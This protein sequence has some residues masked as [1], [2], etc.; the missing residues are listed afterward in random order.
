[1]TLN[2]VIAFILCFFSPNSIAL[3]AHYV[4]VAEDRPIMSVKYCLPVP[5]FHF[6]PKLTHSA[7]LSL[8]DSWASCILSIRM[9]WWLV[10]FCRTLYLVDMSTQVKCKHE[11]P[12]HKRIIRKLPHMHSNIEV[13]TVLVV[14]TA[15]VWVLW[16]YAWNKC[17]FIHSNQ[18][19][20]CNFCA[21]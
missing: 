12:I 4:T 20:D 11:V 3:Q 9:N 10:I 21:F 6:W 2:G 17:S 7:A 19:A 8:C 5:I 14:D 16:A 18:W 15:R 1:M 13:Q